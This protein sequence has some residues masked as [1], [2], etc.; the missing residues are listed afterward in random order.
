[1]IY[2]TE[3]GLGHYTT[4]FCCCC[5]VMLGYSQQAAAN[6]LSRFVHAGV[7]NILIVEVKVQETSQCAK[8]L[9][10]EFQHFR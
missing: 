2:F 3:E 10:G 5:L 4:T 8:D 7:S 6:D 9:M 1:M